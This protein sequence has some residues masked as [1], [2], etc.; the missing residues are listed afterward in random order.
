M[1]DKEA[2]KDRANCI[3]IAKHLGI[4]QSSNGRYIAVWRGGTNGNVQID[5]KHWWDHKEDKGGDVFELVCAMNRTHFM[6]SCRIIA[7]F[8]GM[9]PVRPLRV[10]QGKTRYDLL[11]ADG[12][13]EIKR[14]AY[15]DKDGNPI[16]YVVRMEHPEKKKE[17]LQGDTNGKWT[18]KHLDL[19]LYNLPRIKDSSWVLV[20]EGEKDADTLISW[21]LPAT[22]N[23]GGAKSWEDRFSDVLAGK[24]VILLPDNDE[25]GLAH[26]DAIGKSLKGK[27]REIRTLTVSELPKG[28]VTDWVEKEGGDKGRFL[29]MAKVAMQWTAPDDH[30]VELAMAKEAN[31]K[32]F[33]NFVSSFEQTPNQKKPTI[34]KTARSLNEMV[35]DAHI[36]LLGFPR[37]IGESSLFDHDRDTK[38]I[39]YLDSTQKLWAWMHNKMKIPVR[40]TRGDAMVTKGEFYEGLIM[41]A[42]KYESISGVPDWPR[43][44]DVYYHHSE[45]PPPTEGHTAFEKLLDFYKPENHYYRVLLKSLFCAPMFYKRGVERPMWIIDSHEGA[46]SGKSSLAEAVSNL[47]STSPI[48]VAV[49]ELEQSD[50]LIKRMMS[51]EGR[52]AK[53]FLLDNVTGNFK[54]P[55]LSGLVTAPTITGMAPY[56]RGEE[57]RVNNLTY[58]VTANS[59]SVDNDIG[60]RSFYI[61]LSKPDYNAEWK[62]QMNAYIDQNRLQIFA[63]IIDLLSNSKVIPVPASTRFPEFEQEILQKCCKNESE[64]KSVQAV[65]LEARE[66]SNNEEELAMQI[67]EVLAERI[68]DI[69]DTPKYHQFFIPTKTVWMWLKDG[70]EGSFKDDSDAIQ[71]VRDFS[72]NRLLHSILPKPDRFPHHETNGVKKRKGV[73]WQGSDYDPAHSKR[74]VVVYKDRVNTPV[75]V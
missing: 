18:V 28:D 46:G 4:P 20:V 70:M 34:E 60:I 62:S 69:H 75:E 41:G 63:D 17:F 26:M 64:L 61:Y 40:W 47:Y 29:A 1:Y 9:K 31:R 35:E 43:R 36:R 27:A 22:T 48:R 44:S 72:K 13:E 49:P 19:V 23:C 37:R 59:A 71:K 11:L 8:Y 52:N 30:T 5:E 21:G 15:T 25:V 50:R 24:D 45:L 65:I 68:A 73:M 66:E 32:P 39:I 42:K 57:I 2:L 58:I 33:G 74:Y 53:V 54:S 14:Y 55:F 56:G 6:E 38:E 7:D 3:E 12:Y 16:H 67:E 10:P 51:T